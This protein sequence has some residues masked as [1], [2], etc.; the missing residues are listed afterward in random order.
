MQRTQQAPWRQD[1]ATEGLPSPGRRLKP[2]RSKKRPKKGRKR[3]HV[4][5]AQAIIMG[6][7]RR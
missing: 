7:P 4:D 1:T 5:A 6:E 2:K 3:A